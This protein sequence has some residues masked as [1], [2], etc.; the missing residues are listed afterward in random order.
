MELSGNQSQPVTL[1]HQFT[2]PIPS[3]KERVP[4]GCSYQFVDG[5]DQIS[6]PKARRVTPLNQEFSHALIDRNRAPLFGVMLDDRIKVHFGDFALRFSRKRSKD[7]RFGKPSAKLRSHPPLNGA[8]DVLFQTG[9]RQVFAPDDFGATEVR[10]EDEIDATEVQNFAIGQAQPGCINTLEEQLNEFRVSL[11][12]LVKQPYPLRYLP[13]TLTDEADVSQAV[14]EKPIVALECLKFG[15]VETHETRFYAQRAGERRRQKGFS[16]PGRTREN[17]G[18]FRTT[19]RNDIE[20]AALHRAREDGHNVKLSP[21]G[22]GQGS[23]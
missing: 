14:A 20:L 18:T 8:D 4:D 11:F 6:S 15:T 10:R 5:A 13:V 12:N 2:G 7:Q 3:G 21:H 19:L 16:N 22:G 23:L 17:I 1:N 9:E